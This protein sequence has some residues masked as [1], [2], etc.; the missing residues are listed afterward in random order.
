LVGNVL[1]P[2]IWAIN[3][4]QHIM[5]TPATTEYIF[6][7]P[8]ARY[9]AGYQDALGDIRNSRDRRFIEQGKTFCLPATNKMYCKGYRQAF[10][11][12]LNGTAK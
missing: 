10:V 5:N 9:N 3:E 7:T 2:Y 4:Q 11:D 1:C 6:N 8:L 12:R